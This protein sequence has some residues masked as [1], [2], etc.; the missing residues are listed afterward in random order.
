VIDTPFSNLPTWVWVIGVIFGPTGAVAVGVIAFRSAMLA[1]MSRMEAAV[2]DLLA[3]F[4][5]HVDSDASQ[6]LSIATALGRV[7]GKFHD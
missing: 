1:S 7:E 4:R 5:K 3:E 2:T 6:F